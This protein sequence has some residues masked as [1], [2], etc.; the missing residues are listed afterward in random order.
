MGSRS[1]ALSGRLGGSRSEIGRIE[2]RSQRRRLDVQSIAVKKSKWKSWIGARWNDAYM[3]SIS[4]SRV[5]LALPLAALLLSCSCDRRDGTSQLPT[6]TEVFHLRS[7]CAELGRKFESNQ[8]GYRF[9]VMASHYDP[10][11]S[12]CY[13]E[14]TVVDSETDHQLYDG[15]TGKLLA[16]SHVGPRGR[17]G[18][19]RP[20]V[21]TLPKDDEARFKVVE[22]FIGKMMAEDRMRETSR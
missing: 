20:G 12:R 18:E 6:A 9:V 13:V 15:Q 22:A 7:E 11:T 17:T 14:V 16:S 2:S 21:L 5:R 19:A 4:G 10:K 8:V 1:P 3:N